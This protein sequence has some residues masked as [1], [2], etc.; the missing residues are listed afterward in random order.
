M[1]IPSLYCFIMFILC[2][3]EFLFDVF[4]ISAERLMGLRGRF[5]LE[6]QIVIF[7]SI[8][9]GPNHVLFLLLKHIKKVVFLVVGTLRSGSPLYLSGSYFFVNFCLVVRGVYPS[10]SLT[11][12]TTKKKIFYVSSL[13]IYSLF[14]RYTYYMAFWVTY[15]YQMKREWTLF[16]KLS[17]SVKAMNCV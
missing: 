15:L 9:C 2:S 17:L 7:V 16:I 13:T 12:R 6:K 14:W 1:D 8:C 11:G 3:I 10:P 5:I 4:S